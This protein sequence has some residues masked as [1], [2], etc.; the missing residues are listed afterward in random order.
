[1]T[2][3]NSSGC[4]ENLSVTGK[5]AKTPDTSS[6]FRFEL[7]PSRKSTS[8]NPDELI[9]A[10]KPNEADGTGFDCACAMEMLNTS[11]MIE[12]KGFLII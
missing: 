6:M 7:T 5:M 3:Y 10:R 9:P 11:N 4:I 8:L 12:R 1:M 2:E